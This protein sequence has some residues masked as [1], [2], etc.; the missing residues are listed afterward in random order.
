[1]KFGAWIFAATLAATA[2]A[3]GETNAEDRS[4][5]N[6]TRS[7]GRGISNNTRLYP[8]F[9]SR[10][11]G[12]K[13]TSGTQ[14]ESANTSADKGQVNF[15][16]R[17]YRLKSAGP[18]AGIRGY[19]RHSGSSGMRRIGS[20]MH[21]NRDAI[22]RTTDG[23]SVF[24]SEFDSNGSDSDGS[25]KLRG[26]R[27]R[28]EKRPEGNR[29]KHADYNHDADNNDADAV[30]HI[31]GRQAAPQ[32]RDHRHA[33]DSQP[34]RTA[35]P[36]KP[37]VPPIPQRRSSQSR[38]GGIRRATFSRSKLVTEDIPAG[39]QTPMVRVKWEQRSDLNVGQECECQLVVKNTGSI[40]AH[41]VLV[42]ADFPESVRVT[43]AQPEPV[44]AKEQAVWKFDGLAAGEE[45]VIQITMIPSRPGRLRTTAS[46]RFTGRAGGDFIVKEPMLKVSMSGPAEV[47]VGEAA[48]QLIEISN[49]GTGIAKNVAIEAWIPKG[50]EHP[51]GD[52][53]MMDIGA[54]NPGESRKVRLSLT[55]IE[56]GKQS[57]RVKATSQATLAQ[58]GER[59]VNVESPS[60]QVAIDGPKLR[61]VGRNAAYI[62]KITNDGTVA[63][64]NVRVRHQLPDGCRFLKADH[65]GSYNADKR[66]IG[67]FVGRV[68]PGQTVTVKAVVASTQLGQ[69]MHRAGAIS[70]QGAR[71]ETTFT[72][73]VDGTS[74]LEVEIHNPDDPVEVGLAT[75][76]E[77]RVRNT[78]TKADSNV[79]LT[80]ELPEDVE[81]LGAKGPTRAVAEKGQVVF[82]GLGELPPGKTAL[83]RIQ[84]RGTAPGNH[85][86]R[87]RLSSESVS[88]P[89]IYDEVT[90][91]Y[92]D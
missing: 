11:R 72:T 24:D 16:S 31:G 92:A 64:N 74:S 17:S 1:M 52:R 4:P 56:G 71:A 29:L 63:T 19:P 38:S 20:G 22:G 53:L 15:G 60:L 70:E 46:V 86:L 80:C 5:A 27:N 69:Q 21:R 81:L 47:M 82:K 83:Y 36:L 12:G 88:Q 85:R 45:R 6:H 54:L 62:I 58:Q 77:I 2:A 61:Y 67:W 76:Y 49:P 9:Y 34:R 18:A 68:K 87:V 65:G 59:T 40:D 75:T 90:K 89:L 7:D 35:G 78:G 42:M 14:A 84:V 13:P 50:L 23:R 25:T 55:A 10:P 37:P 73:K 30:H 43:G 79:A 41:H 28:S 39:P 44:E 66:S 8:H 33:G 32:R 3:C 51:R 91:F 26:T 57:I 48:S